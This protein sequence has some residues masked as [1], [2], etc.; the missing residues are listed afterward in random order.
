M[1]SRRPELDLAR[2]RRAKVALIERA[3]AFGELDPPRLTDVQMIRVIDTLGRG[4]LIV[5]KPIAASAATPSQEP[6]R[7]AEAVRRVLPE[8]YK[9]DRNE[10]RAAVQRERAVLGLSDRRKTT[11]TLSCLSWQNEP[12]FLN[13]SNGLQF[14]TS[15]G[16]KPVATVRVATHH[17]TGLW[18]GSID[19]GTYPHCHAGFRDH[20]DR[21]ALIKLYDRASHTSC[22]LPTTPFARLPVRRC[23][24]RLP[25]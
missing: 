14:S 6:D 15:S 23:P 22:V 17:G 25:I 13:G 21:A 7:S 24:S 10:R 2:V 4:R 19:L 18:S 11:T 16:C 12:N 9:L 8:L 3:S 20:C 5:P 1:L